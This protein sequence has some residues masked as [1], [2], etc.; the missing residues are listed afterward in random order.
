MRPLSIPIYP[1]LSQPG[2]NIIKT[3]VLQEEGY[4]LGPDV[5]TFEDGIS[6]DISLTNTGEAILL[7]GTADTKAHTHCSRCLESVELDLHGEIEGY[8]L[9]SRETQSDEG[10][11]EDEYDYVSDDETVDIAP[12]ILSGLILDMPMM[13]L[14]KPECLGLCPTCGKNL[15]E[16]SCDCTSQEPEDTGNPF[17]ALKGYMFED[18]PSAD[19]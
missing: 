12:A 1:G 15:N 8:F 2:D 4:Q 14:C 6:Y 7:S 16:G 19:E 18:A 5:Y 13:P 17:S 10:L 9:I 3:G 11:D